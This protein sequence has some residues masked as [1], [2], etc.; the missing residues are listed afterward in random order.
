MNKKVMILNRDDPPQIYDF[1]PSIK[2]CSVK[3][4][5]NSKIIKN[6]KII[7]ALDSSNLNRTG[8]IQKL[9]E[10]QKVM[11]N[12]DHHCSN[13]AFGNINYI[14]TSASSTGE[15]IFDFINYL[16]PEI[17]D[18]DIATCLFSSIMT[19][20]GSFKYE[21]TTEKTFEIASKLMST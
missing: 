6:T 19:D 15:I 3:K 16:H 9:L 2:E 13:D 4:Y 18:K 20:T 21:N 5:V 8:D 17:M 11:I 7:I 10:N 1:L 12:I 14:D